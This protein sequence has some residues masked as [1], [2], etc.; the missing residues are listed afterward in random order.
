MLLWDLYQN[1][2][3]STARREADAAQS[4]SEKTAYELDKL[5]HQVDKLSLSCQA[6]WELLRDHSGLTEDDIQ[7]K[8][9]EVDGRSGEVNGKMGARLVDCPSCGNPTSSARAACD[10]CGGAITSDHCFQG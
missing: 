3:I 2:N 7:A 8:I 6:M 10:R 5:K 4:S 9:V 1:K